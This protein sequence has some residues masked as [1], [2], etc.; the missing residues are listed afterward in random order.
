MLESGV[1]QFY[2]IKLFSFTAACMDCSG[3]S[4]TNGLPDW[5]YQQNTS[6]GLHHSFLSYFKTKISHNTRDFVKTYQI[7]TYV[8]RHEIIFTNTP[9]IG[10][11]HV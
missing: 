4:M 9:H 5:C 1:W 2:E 7:S 11:R 10:R 8:N 6:T 3:M